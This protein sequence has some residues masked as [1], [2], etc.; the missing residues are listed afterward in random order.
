MFIIL[1]LY[2]LKKGGQ[3]GK[4]TNQD[5][6]RAYLVGD[7]IP[8]FESEMSYNNL[9][10]PNI[11]EGDIDSDETDNLGYFNNSFNDVITWKNRTW[12]TKNGPFLEI[13]YTLPDNIGL[14]EEDTTT[15]ARAIWEFRRRTCVKYDSINKSIN[16]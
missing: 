14:T 16:A 12:N 13:P 15:I 2:I 5:F 7:S 3:N 4:L 1:Y 10:D 9:T 11:F 6:V 8:S